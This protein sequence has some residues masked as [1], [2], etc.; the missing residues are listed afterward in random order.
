MDKVISD[1][2]SNKLK[3]FAS[4]KNFQIKNLTS[5]T[6]LENSEKCSIPDKLIKIIYFTHFREN[7][8]H[9]ELYDIE[10][11]YLV[12]VLNFII[13]FSLSIFSSIVKFT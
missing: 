9:V 13:C 4:P 3:P 7:E 1:R 11:I 10:S 12:N 2:T 8:V 5:F 6:S